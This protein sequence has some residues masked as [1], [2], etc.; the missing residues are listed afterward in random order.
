MERA[1]QHHLIRTVVSL[2]ELAATATDRRIRDDL[3][4]EAVMALDIA[5]ADQV[6]NGELRK[7]TSNLTALLTRLERTDALDQEALAYANLRLLRLQS[8]L[9][10]DPE[11]KRMLP[12]IPVS[13]MIPV[14]ASL[15][16]IGKNQEQVLSWVRA[17]PGKRPHELIAYFSGKL[18][19]RTIKRSLKDLVEAK[20]LRRRE[21]DGV[22]AYEPLDPSEGS[23]I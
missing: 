10:A 13:S 20:L 12:G 22:V 15:P 9:G 1:A 4:D 2:C 5:A 17:N 19:S 14:S 6:S 7:W 11:S 21:H 3:A 18:S 8:S 16:V 23:A